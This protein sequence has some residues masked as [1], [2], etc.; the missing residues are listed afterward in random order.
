VQLNYNLQYFLQPSTKNIDG[1]KLQM[2]PNGNR[3]GLS[4]SL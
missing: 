1:D 4:L 3:F 2:T